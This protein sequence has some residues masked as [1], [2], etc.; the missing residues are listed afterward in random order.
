M[1]LTN[2]E[3]KAYFEDYGTVTDTD[4]HPTRGFG[5]VTF[6]SK[7]GVRNSL[8]NPVH[9]LKNKCVE[10]KVAEP[11]AESFQSFHHCGLAQARV[12][13]YYGNLIKPDAF[14]YST[15]LPMC[16]CLS[17]RYQNLTPLSDFR[18]SLFGSVKLLHLDEVEDEGNVGHDTKSGDNEAPYIGEDVDWEGKS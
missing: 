6:D 7:E 18:K 14:G 3:L 16:H 11:R 2:E 10:A 5:F 13:Y 17:T 9:Y 4:I 1:D 15:Y 8:E 12:P